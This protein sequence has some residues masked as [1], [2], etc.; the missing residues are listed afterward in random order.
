MTPQMYLD[1]GLAVGAIAGG[2]LWFPLG[3]FVGRLIWSKR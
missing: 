1:F 3:L 2:L